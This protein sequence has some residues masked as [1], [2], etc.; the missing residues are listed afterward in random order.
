MIRILSLPEAA[1]RL[2]KSRNQIYKDSVAGLF[3]L[4]ACHSA[5]SDW[6]LESDIEALWNAAGQTPEQIKA[7]VMKLAKQQRT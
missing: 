6:W 5:R 4:P 3:P 1:A 7:L 2:G